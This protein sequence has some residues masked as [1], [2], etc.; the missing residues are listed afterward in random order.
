M[1]KLLSFA[2]PLTGRRKSQRPDVIPVDGVDST[3][4]LLREQATANH[5]RVEAPS[6]QRPAHHGASSRGAT[7]QPARRQ[8]NDH[9]ARTS[10]IQWR[11]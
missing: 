2:W 5:R 6:Q 11:P 10:P 7:E 4:A 3:L 1:T 8:Q 9:A